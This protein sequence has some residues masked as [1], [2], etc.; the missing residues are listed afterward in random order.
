ML[1]RLTRIDYG[2]VRW[3][4]D[5]HLQVI[6]EMFDLEGDEPAFARLFVD[7]DC[8]KGLFPIYL[9][10]INVVKLMKIKNYI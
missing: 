3:G 10:K 8:G 5:A 2:L 4:K 6:V 9:E 1:G 7:D